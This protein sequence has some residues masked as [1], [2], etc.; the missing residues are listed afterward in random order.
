MSD[1]TREALERMLTM[2][3]S[4]W[5]E[6]CG[7][8]DTLKQKL[9]EAEKKIQ[10]KININQSEALLNTSLSR[11]NKKLDEKLSEAL[12]VIKVSAQT[13]GAIDAFITMKPHLEEDDF[14]LVLRDVRSALGILKKHGLEKV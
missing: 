2:K 13:F 14:N 3:Q 10:E 12:E 9:A 5:I 7:E 4:D 6:A 11:E 1:T 8:I